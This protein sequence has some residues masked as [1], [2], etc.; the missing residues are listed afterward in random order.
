MS[1]QILML[2]TILNATELAMGLRGAEA[3]RIYADLCLAVLRE[4]SHGWSW[5]KYAEVGH[6]EGSVLLLV[7]TLCCL[8]W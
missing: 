6:A 5:L 4:V 2:Q 3:K 1:P 8:T 7:L